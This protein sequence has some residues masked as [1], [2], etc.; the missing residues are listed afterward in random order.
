[1][2]VEGSFAKTLPHEVLEFRSR[3]AYMK[4]VTAANVYLM[5][6]SR[7]EIEEFDNNG[8]WFAVPRPRR[9]T[10]VEFTEWR[11]VASVVRRILSDERS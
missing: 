10:S 2:S 5:E 9:V 4:R 11:E 8:K 3:Q 7:I 6:P 1:M